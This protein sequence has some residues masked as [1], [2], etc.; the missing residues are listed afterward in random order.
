MYSIKLNVNDNIFDKVMFFLNNIPTN[1][2]KTKKILNN[3][4]SNNNNIVEF[5]QSSP[6]S[7]E[8]DISRKNEKYINRVEF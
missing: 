2:L 7:E 3:E 5:F 6:L 8:I 1:E 4:I